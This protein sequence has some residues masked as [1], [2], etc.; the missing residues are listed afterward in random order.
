[1]FYLVWVKNISVLTYKLNF[2]KIPISKNDFIQ[3]LYQ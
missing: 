2:E 3:N 1:M